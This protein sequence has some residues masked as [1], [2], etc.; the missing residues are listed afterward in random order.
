MQRVSEVNGIK[1]FDKSA[2]CINHFEKKH[3]LEKALSVIKSF[4]TLLFYTLTKLSLCLRRVEKRMEPLINVN[5]RDM[6]KKRLVVC[7]H[8]LN[9]NPSQ[10]E[11][12]V[13]EMNEK[14][15]SDTDVFIPR[16]LQ[17]GNA[18]LDEMV[19]PI[20]N[21]IDLWCATSGEKELVL[22]G[23]SNGGRIARAIDSRISTLENGS[24][25]KKLRFISIVGA[26]KGSALVNLA[27]K[28]GLSWMMSKNISEEMLT[29]SSSN[30]LLNKQWSLELLN[31]SMT[32]EYTFIASPHDWQVP[33]YSSSLMEV[34]DCKAC[35]AIIPGHGHNS[36]VNAAAKTV[37]EVI[38]S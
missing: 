25:I 30:A 27:R 22:V 21:V 26:C 4:G 6:S 13:D 9:N 1:F 5:K 2:S 12:I 11:K 8:G 32:R 19:R 20:L 7:I 35:Y 36:I 3:W 10:F 28:V 31:K 14:G 23:I 38:L 29:D 24:N 16:V 15:H 18:K 34:Q 33:N 17:K 37:A